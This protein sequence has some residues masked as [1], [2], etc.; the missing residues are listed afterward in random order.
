MSFPIIIVLSIIYIVFDLTCSSMVLVVGYDCRKKTAAFWANFCFRLALVVLSY[1][2]D[3]KLYYI[4][5]IV[6]GFPLTFLI[7]YLFIDKNICR[8]MTKF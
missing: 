2:L 8:C 6:L 5:T 4:I 3:S 7:V 1:I